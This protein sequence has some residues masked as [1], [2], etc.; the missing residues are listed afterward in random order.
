MKGFVLTKP[1][2][3]L[4]PKC[5]ADLGTLQEMLADDPKSDNWQTAIKITLKCKQCQEGLRAL[6]R[7]K[8]ALNA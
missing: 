5:G 7:R 2:A 8:V 3:N 4:C 1:K 6:V